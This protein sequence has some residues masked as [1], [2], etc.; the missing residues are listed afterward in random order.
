[1][2]LS[3]WTSCTCCSAA[4][5][6]LGTFDNSQREYLSTDIT[7]ILYMDLSNKSG[8]YSYLKVLLWASVPLIVSTMLTMC[9]FSCILPN[10]KN[11]KATHQHTF[12]R[13]TFLY[14]KTSSSGKQLLSCRTC[15]WMHLQC[16]KW[17]NSSCCSR[18]L[19]P[20]LLVTWKSFILA[21]KQSVQTSVS[22][23]MM[24]VLN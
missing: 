10:G 16:F 17:A 12:A 9:R 4:H 6:A 18:E 13:L 14:T 21:H 15:K 5:Y 1:M 23:T 8:K 24:Q 20:F 3:S 2:V 7:E 22:A 11:T 19:R